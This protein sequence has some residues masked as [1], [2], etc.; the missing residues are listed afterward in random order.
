[1]NQLEI[2][3]KVLSVDSTGSTIY[4]EVLMFLDRDTEQ[5]REFVKI[6][7]SGNS[8][9]TVT[10]AHLLLVWRPN[11]KLTNYLFAEK[12]EEGDQLLVNSNGILIPQKVVSVTTELLAGFYAPLTQEGT[13]IV[14]SIAASCYAL[15]DSQTIA[16]YSFMPIRTFNKI[17]HW[18]T[19]TDTNET[20]P[21][22][23]GI[24]WYARTLYFIKDY[25]IPT[26][27]LYH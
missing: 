15:I 20:I 16:H 12:V 10:P 24:H 1:M 25:V 6:T 18:F 5:K 27:W 23:N 7:T 8:T 14:D 4:S 3:D 11:K 19:S 26:D 9:I 2:G 13:I 21:K 17:K 22:S